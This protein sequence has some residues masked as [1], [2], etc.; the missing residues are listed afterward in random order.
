MFSA[1]DIL[2]SALGTAVGL[3]AAGIVLGLIGVTSMED[4]AQRV[5]DGSEGGLVA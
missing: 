3:I 2:S 4:V 1:E 5:R